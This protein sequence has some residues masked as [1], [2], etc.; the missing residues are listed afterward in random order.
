[1]SADIFSVKA[2]QLGKMYKLYSSQRARLADLFGFNKLM[3]RSQKSY[4]EFWA[5]RDVSFSVKKGERVGIIGHN[6]AG[7]STLLKTLIGAHAPTEGTMK[8]NGRIQALMQLGTGFHPDFTGRENIRAAL[9]YNNISAAEIARCEEEI[10]DFTELE[11]FIDQPVKNYSAGMYARLAFA[12]ATSIKPEVLIIDEVLGAGDAYF[13]GK[14]VERMKHLSVESGATVLFVSHDLGSVQNMCE[15]CIWIDHGLLRA[16]GPSLDVIKEYSAQVRQREELR[17]KIRNEKKLL[18]KKSIDV[19]YSKQQIF[20][21]RTDHEGTLRFPVTKLSFSYQNSQIAEVIPGMPMDTDESQQAFLYL[22]QTSNGWGD[23]R[24]MERGGWCR[25]AILNH[26]HSVC[27]GVI[28]QDNWEM[29]DLSVNISFDDMA[30]GSVRVDYFDSTDQ[31][32]HPFDKLELKNTQSST[33]LQLSLSQQSSTATP[34]SASEAGGKNG[35]SAVPGKTVSAGSEAQTES[36]DD[37][38]IFD[39]YG[40]KEC[41]IRRVGF[42]VGGIETFLIPKSSSLE[43]QMEYEAYKDLENPIFVFCVY[44]PSGQP[45]AQVYHDTGEFIDDAVLKKGRGIFSFQIKQ[46][47]LGPGKYIASAAIFKEYP[48]NGIEPKA[49]YLIDRKIEF[50]IFSQESEPIAAGVCVQPTTPLWKALNN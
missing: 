40:S 32:Y 7:K 50:E 48:K 8:I 26:N 3:F 30:S 45:A 49:Y 23:S 36:M 33:S 16:D 47:L 12:T 25:D 5:L 13:A 9:G 1:M 31:S 11:D 28:I 42:L 39:E 17:L 37:T 2:D 22:N 20:Q 38:M 29:K 24:K 46:L 14:C 34:D 21:L 44:L 35:E 4:R 19:D 15:R 41:L 18:S 10:I 6:G 27:F 43:I